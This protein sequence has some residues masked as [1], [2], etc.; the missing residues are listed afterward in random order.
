MRAYT[1]LR[2][3]D[4]ARYELVHGDLIGR[5]QSAA[6]CL[7]DA[8]ISEAHAMISLREQELK[9]IALRGA[10]AVNGRPLNDVTLKEGMEIVLARGYAIEVEEVSLPKSVMGIE[11]PGIPRQ[12]LPSVASLFITGESPGRLLGQDARVVSGYSEGAAA[13]IWFTGESWRLRIGQE[14]VRTVSPGEQFSL[15]GALI[16]WVEIPLAAAGLAPT[17]VQGGVDA[18]LKLEAHFDTVHLH[19]EGHAAVVLGGVPARIVSE[20]VALKG[21]A[22][23]TVLAGLLWPKESDLEAVRSRFDVN[24]SRLRRKLREAH[25]RTDLIHSDGS[26]QI[27]LLL[28]PHDIVEDRT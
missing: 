12:A 6:M 8:R 2:A 26:G 1:R 25:I 7:D 24:L 11:G 21:P 27:G 17:R 9:L 19:R 22:H 14:P 10:F 13:W 18:P 16:S 15:N 3:P 5:L 4:G 23:W 28:Y 20:L